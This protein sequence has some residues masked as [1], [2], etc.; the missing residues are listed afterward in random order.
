VALGVVERLDVSANLVDHLLRTFGLGF[1]IVNL[2]EE[3]THRRLASLQILP[4]MR[5]CRRLLAHSVEDLFVEAVD[6]C[7]Q[8]G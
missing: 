6:L 3:V 1:D 5:A 7:L 2:V 4:R 8:L